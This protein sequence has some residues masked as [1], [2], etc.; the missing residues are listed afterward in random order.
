MLKSFILSLLLLCA[1]FVVY[2]QAVEDAPS[3]VETNFSEL[4]MEDSLATSDVA[5]IEKL[6]DEGFDFNKTDDNGNP[7]LY[8]ILSRN[9]NLEVAKKAIEYGADVNKPAKNG[10]IPLNIATSKA[11]EL[12]LQIMMMKTMGLNTE[13]TKIQEELKDN[14]FREMTRAIEMTQLLIDSGAD[15]NLLSSL[16]TPLMNAVTNVWNL[17]IVK[18]LI[19]A[20][21]DLNLTD[22][23]GRTALFY[24]FAS[25]NDEV[26]NLL[27]ESGADVSIKDAD[28]KIYSEMPKV[29]VEPAI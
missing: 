17:D 24:A 6:K 16:G 13:D 15:V 21:A 4:G 2:A 9:P 5:T 29:S 28:G 1:P 10:M 20:K 19:D 11:N 3:K 14:L 18:M 26:V 22:K 12:Q 8:Y 25:S 27:I 23:K 7:P